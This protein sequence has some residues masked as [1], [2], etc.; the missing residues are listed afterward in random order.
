MSVPREDITS[1]AFSILK[2]E[3]PSESLHSLALTG[4]LVHGQTALTDPTA[5]LTIPQLCNP[6]LTVGDG[7]D[8]L[9]PVET[10]PEVG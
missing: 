1:S 7:E 9:L 8:D 3:A 10:A 2:T 6:N 4:G 5:G